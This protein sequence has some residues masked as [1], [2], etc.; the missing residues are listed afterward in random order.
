MTCT[1]L[2]INMVILVTSIV[3][4]TAC[5]GWKS[6]SSAAAE[7]AAALQ[8]LVGFDFLHNSPPACSVLLF[9]SSL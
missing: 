2:Y 5:I 3:V 1:M 9:P 8:L 6:S 4:T 7:A